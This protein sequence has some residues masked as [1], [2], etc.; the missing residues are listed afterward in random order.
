MTLETEN[1]ALQDGATEE[2]LSVI[3]DDDDARGGWVI[4]TSDDGSFLQAAGKGWSP[5]TLEFF[6]GKDAPRY[7]Q[8]TQLNKDQ[9]RFALTDFFNNG[10]TW[11]ASFEWREVSNNGCLGVLAI[12]ALVVLGAVVSSYLISTEV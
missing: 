5:Y 9:V 8:A 1:S 2:D 6:P 10:K 11:R 12:S 3:F 7:Q 4:L